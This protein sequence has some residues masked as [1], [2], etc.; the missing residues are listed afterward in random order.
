MRR[1]HV[2]RIA[3][4]NVVYPFRRLITRH[5]QHQHA[6]FDRDAGIHTT[7]TVTLDELGLSPDESTRYGATPIH[8]F[9]SL[10]TKLHLSYQ[11]TVFVD[12]GSG[13]GRTLLLASHYPFRS[14]VGVDISPALCKIANDNIQRYRVRQ[15]KAADILVFCKGIDEFEYDGLAISDHLL[16]YMFNPC[17]ASVLKPAIQKLA[18]LTQ[19]GVS[20]TIIYVNPVWVDV[21]ASAPWLTQ[22]RYGETFDDTGNSFMEYVIFQGLP[23]PWREATEVLTFQIGPWVLARWSFP[24]VSNMANPIANSRS[25]KPPVLKPVTYRQMRDNGALRNTLSFDQGTIRYVPYRG[26]RYFIDL[27]SRSFDTYFK[28]FSTKT[29]NTLRR[30][31][32][33]FRE[34]SGGTIDLRA[35]ASSEEIIEFRQHA[36]AVSLLTY[37]RRIGMAFPEDEEFERLI[38][39]EAKEGRVRGFVLMHDNRPVAYAFCRVHADIITYAIL[40]HD[41]TFGRYSPGTVLLLLVIERSFLEDKIRIFDFGG[42]ELDYKLFFSTGSVNYLKVIWFPVTP[43]NLLLV[44]AHYLTLQAWR[45]AAW[46]KDS[47]TCCAHGVK[48]FLGR[49]LSQ[50]GPNNRLPGTIPASISSRRA[51]ERARQRGRQ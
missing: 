10:L 41:P 26:K 37:Q 47:G 12:F 15:R 18:R 49:L 32:R 40:G 2:V 19:Q 24:S 48:A 4:K 5:L 35:Y 39:E 50:S 8:F 27:S 46:L 38:I 17:S 22:V 23:E 16:I 13:K 25:S 7:G 1:H 36:I 28:K 14:I 6:R 20:V 42:M 21:L 3:A 29:K 51:P 31:V 45:G 11:R 44:L 30:K 9:H 33:R 34:F 43:K